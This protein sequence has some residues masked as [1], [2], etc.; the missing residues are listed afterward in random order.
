MKRTVS[1]SLG[2]PSRYKKIIVDLNGVQISVERIGTGGDAQ[3]AQRLFT[4]LDG[5]VDVLAV[6]GID[7]YVHLEGRDYPIRAALKLV[8]G[9]HQVLTTTPVYEGRTFGVNMV[10]GMLTAYSGLNRQ[11]TIPELNA[12]ID[13]VNLRPSLHILNR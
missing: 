3:A 9:V 7:L 13:E 8:Q 5:Q 6:G 4:E 1:I 12:L 11:P 2:S 10:E